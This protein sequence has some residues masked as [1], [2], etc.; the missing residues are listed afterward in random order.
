GRSTLSD[1]AL[2]VFGFNPEDGNTRATEEVRSRIHVEDRQGVQQALQG[3]LEKSQ[4]YACEFR[5]ALPDGNERWA[6]VRGSATRDAQGA[7]RTV[8]AIV[9]VTESKRA[10]E[11]LKRSRTLLVEAEKLSHTGAWEWDLASNRWTFSDEWLAIHGCRNRTLQPEELLSI[12]HP[13]DRSAITQAFEAVRQGV[14]P[15]DLEHR[16]VRLDSGEVRVVRAQGQYVQDSA[17]KVVRVY[18]FA[19]DITERKRAEEAL[20]ESETRFRTLADNISQFAWMADAN[21]WI[22]WYNTR[23]YEY[24]GTTFEEMQGWGWQKVHHPDHVGRV[25]DKFRMH[26][27]AGQAWED[28]FPLLGKDGQYR[29]FLSRAMPIRGE[30]DKVIRWFGTNTDITEQKQAQ[31]ELRRLKDELE[32]RVEQRTFELAAANKELE[33]FGYS[34]SHDLRAPLRHLDS[35]IKLLQRSAAETLDEKS[36]RYVQILSSSAQRMGQL[37]DDLLTLSR[38]G[39]AAMSE[40]EVNLRQLINEARQE[41][42]PAMAGRAIEWTVGT[43]PRLRGDYTLLRSAVVNLL[44]NAIKYT[45]Q[46]HPARIEVGSQ[47]EDHEVVC[48]VRDNGAGFD[49]QFVDKLFGVFQRLHRAEDFEGTGIGL[50][51]VRRVIQRHG[52]RTWAEGELERGA[53]VYFSFPRDRIVSNQKS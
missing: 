30:Q 42:A 34:V 19:Q 2:R 53:T 36:R 31:D 21:G 23:W 17:G 33:A 10:E 45:R 35:F 18:G 46:R 22:F 43:L 16:I 7:I 50:A 8:G 5:L 12:A 29:W 9:D 3:A 24:T 15:Y 4:E 13:E 51:S 49:M 40:K 44:S 41:L 6:L 27:E 25:V 1:V 37:I 14:A 47:E 38:L 48:F 11:D 20:R 52:G 28:T 26:I 39:R 32:V